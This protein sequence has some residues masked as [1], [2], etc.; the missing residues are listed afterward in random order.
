[1]T[2]NSDFTL[3]GAKLRSRLML[4]YECESAQE[5]RETFA[6]FVQDTRKEERRRRR[7]RR[8]WSEDV[9][10]DTTRCQHAPA[11]VVAVEAHESVTRQASVDA[12]PCNDLVLPRLT[13]L[14]IPPCLHRVSEIGVHRPAARVEA[15]RSD[16]LH[17]VAEAERMNHIEPTQ[18]QDRTE[19]RRE[20]PV[21][22][23]A[24]T[25][26]S[27]ADDAHGIF[28]PDARCSSTRND[29]DVM[30]TSR[31][32]RRQLVEIAFTAAANGRP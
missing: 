6:R 32:S 15:C 8:D 10:P 13:R 16:G 25:G 29:R 23:I 27:K 21:P 5:I 7:A 22:G 31:K 4:E 20:Q 9:G 24:S 30:T 28:L 17:R 11:V 14:L 12:D 19:R 18:S 1:M 26:P 2:S 3:Y